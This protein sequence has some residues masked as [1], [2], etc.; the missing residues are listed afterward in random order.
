[1]LTLAC[2]QSM[3]YITDYNSEWPQRFEHI[4]SYLTPF[5]PGSCQIHHVGSTAIPG[6]PAKDIIDL[7]IECPLNMMQTVI[8]ALKKAGYEHEGDKGILGREAFRP[9]QFTEAASLPQHHLYAC[10]SGTDELKKHLAYRD[11]LLAYPDRAEW[12]AHQKVAVDNAAESR[13][14]Y[15]QNKSKFY[16]L[17]IREALD[18]ANTR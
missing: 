8:A 9:N 12:L 3:H 7:D 5:L 17:I 15:I 10:E 14:A 16:L 2:N 4:T 11:Y 1:M 6:M 18:W 13:E